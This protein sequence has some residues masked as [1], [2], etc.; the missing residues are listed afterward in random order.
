MNTHRKRY[1]YFLATIGHSV[2]ALRRTMGSVWTTIS[3]SVRR[4]R[5]NFSAPRPAPEQNS[6]A[7]GITIL[8]LMTGD[9]ERR[10]MAELANRKHWRVLFVGSCEEALA[11]LDQLSV[12]VILCDRDLPGTAWREVVHL[13]ARASSRTCVILISKVVDEYLWNETVLRGGYEVIC[14]PLREEDIVRAVRLA[15][16]YWNS[17]TRQAVVPPHRT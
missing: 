5:P 7:S 8:A 1:A 4:T 9:E 13:L 17:A 10:F 15:W 3:G 12:P 6:S 2:L 11:A 16:S 14:K